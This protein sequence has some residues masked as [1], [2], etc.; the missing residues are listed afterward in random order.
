MKYKP[1]QEISLEGFYTSYRILLQIAN[2]FCSELKQHHLH[3][4]LQ[5]SV[6]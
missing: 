6:Y 2:Y 1:K 4:R 3:S 5:L